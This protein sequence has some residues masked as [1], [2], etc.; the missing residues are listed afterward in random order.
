MKAKF[1]LSV[2]CFSV[3]TTSCNDDSL[4]VTS[5]ASSLEMR[6]VKREISPTFDWENTSNIKLEGINAPVTLPWL[7]GC[8]YKYPIRCSK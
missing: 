3:L 4:T 7:Y 6:A 8:F 5:N 1:L 2:F